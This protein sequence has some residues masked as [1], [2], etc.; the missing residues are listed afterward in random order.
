M[1]NLSIKNKLTVVLSII[2]LCGMLAVGASLGGL[3]RVEKQVM[4]M[5]ARDQALAF[6][7][8][9]MLAQGLQ[10]E[11]ALR[12]IVLDFNNERAHKN[13]AE[14]AREFT[15]LTEQ[16]TQLASHDA[17]TLEALQAI[18]ELRNRQ[19]PIQARIVKLAEQE[20]SAAIVLINTDETPLWR[21]LRGRLVDLTKVKKTELQAAVSNIESIGKTTVR[22]SV[23][24]GILA[25]LVLV[26]AGYWLTRSITRPLAE[27]VDAANRLAAGDLTLRLIPGSRDETGQLIAAMANMVARLAQTIGAVRNASDTLGCASQEITSTAQCLAQSSTE[28]AASVEQTS[29]SVEQMGASIERNSGNAKLTDG[30]A[31]KSAHAAGEGATTVRDTVVAMQ[32]I[33]AKIGIIDDIAY[34][35][36]LL[37]LNAAIEAARAGKH[38]KGFAVVAAEVRK[39]AER[40]Q[41]AAQEISQVAQGSVQLAERAG[42]LFDDILPSITKT[43]KLVQEISG[44]SLEQSSG[45]GQIH[46]AVNQLKQT[47][48]QTAS[49]SEELAATA[50]T[51]SGQVDELQQLMS[52]FQLGATHEVPR[53]SRVTTSRQSTPALCLATA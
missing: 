32:Q 22:T 13:M 49:A 39:L 15:Q 43:S 38:G 36:N 18:T 3:L 25:L 11:Q 40:S 41:V 21:N 6:A 53:P 31:T 30:I 45:V 24:I 42:T 44:A 34:Q 50:D 12:N 23:S 8:T 29:A 48:Q 1:K 9:E 4:E 52:F 27:A 5:T 17:A 2:M 19:Q 47:T 10:M 26:V 20:P 46:A 16:A 33:A 28:Q 14:A 37:A 35:T 51:M 7:S